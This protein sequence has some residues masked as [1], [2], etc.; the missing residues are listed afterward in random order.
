ANGA[1]TAELLGRTAEALGER[2]WGAGILG[3]VPEALRAE[4]LAAIRAARPRCVLIAGGKPAQAKALEAEGIATFLHVPSPI[5]LR[6]FLDAGI[7]RFV[8]EGAECGGHIGPRSSFVLWE[9]QLDVLREHGADDVEVLFAGGIHDPRSA[10][11]VSAMAGPLNGGVGVL[12]GTAYLF[13]EEAVTHG[14]I[15]E[16]FQDRVLDAGSTVTLETA[17]GHL[18]RCL[19]SPYTDEFAAVKAGLR[20]DGV[21]LQETWQRLEE[22][23]TGRLRIASKGIKRQG[24]ALVEVD[25][26]G[27][28]AEGMYMAGQVTVLREDRTDIAA[29][30]WE[31]TEGAAELLA[32]R[33]RDEESVVDSDIAIVGMACVFPGAPDLPAFWSNVLHGADAVTEV[34]DQRWDKEIYADQ[35]TSKWGG[36]LPPVDFDPL[37][38]GI[39]PKSMGSIDPAQLVSLQTARRA[40]ED[41]GYGEGGFDRERTSVIFGAEAGGDLANAGVLRALL[42]SYLEDVPEE[43]LGQLPELTEDSFP[44]TLANVISGRIANRLDLG[45]TNYT[46]DAACGS[47]LAALDLAVKELRA[48]TSSMVLCGAVDLHNGVN[49]YLMFTSAG[50]LSPTGR[51]RPFDASADGIALGEGVACL[52]LKRRSDAE[53]DGDRVYA[54]VKGVGAASDGKALG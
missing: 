25:T 23:N 42:P 10:A 9:Q 12:M 48:G 21:T 8:F 13:T 49:D 44:G 14:A 34:P 47:S 11:M 43:L 7:R 30:H 1:K 28:L 6:Q 54:V 18:T 26:L 36:F 5:L 51:C 50:A 24:D 37:A 46:V 32:T 41:A 53:R 20:A 16:T 3:F 35:S 4:Q 39:P 15:T 52:V 2:P 29:L 45:G 38:Y 19:P 22:L 27:Q 40:L 33:V 31:V 17:P